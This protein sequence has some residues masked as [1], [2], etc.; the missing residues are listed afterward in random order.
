MKYSPL[1]L[2][3]L[4][5]LSADA[6]ITITNTICNYQKGLAVCTDDIRLGWQMQSDVNNDKQTAYQ[7]L[8]TENVT[9]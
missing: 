6:K 4:A 8:V 2:M 3:A 9:G 7:I 1:I 5:A